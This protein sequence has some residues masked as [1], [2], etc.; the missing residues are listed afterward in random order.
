M[1][2][3]HQT[4]AGHG[5]ASRTE[6]RLHSAFGVLPTHTDGYQVVWLA[7]SF[8]D[9]MERESLVKNEGD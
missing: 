4:L 9:P 1:W 7:S 2:H 5:P 3:F 6:V 8:V